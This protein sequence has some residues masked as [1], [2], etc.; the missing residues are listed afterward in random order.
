M[1]KNYSLAASM[2][3]LVACNTTPKY[4]ING[5]VSDPALNG[6]YVYLT[7]FGDKEM[8]TVDSAQIVD[9]KFR[10]NNEL[11]EQNLCFLSINTKAIAP[12][13]P[14]SAYSAVVVL[15]AAPLQA[16]LDSVF[17]TVTGSPENDAFVA[18]KTKVQELQK[19]FPE[20]L[21]V[22][23]S[24]D[25]DAAK[26]AGEKLMN[27]QESVFAEMKAYVE[28][29]KNT[30]TGGLTFVD[31]RY[32]LSEEEQN[33]IIAGADSTFLSVPG[34]DRI[35]KHLEVL[36]TV[37]VG[38]Q[39]VDFEM[40]DVDGKARKLSEFVGQGKV[41]LIDFWASWCGPCRRAMPDLIKTYNAYKGKG[42][43][44]IGISLDSKDAD[45]KKAIKDLGLKWNH[46]SDL[47]GWKSAGGALYGVNSIP[48]TVLVDKDGVIAAKNLHGD[49]L[50]SKIEELLAK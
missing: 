29:H 14:N 11:P 44:V 28:S 22:Y 39:F 37:A 16:H 49:E 1:K 46:L 36:K 13:G 47:K 43:D 30:K 3:L 24:E 21:K 50:N 48:H 38:K 8:Q 45:W 12:F 34:V 2:L 17:S 26:Q 32:S 35:V 6:Q 41:V 25:K 31:M 18:M 9:G 10:F 7:N 5:T 42:F 15:D 20:L 33:A 27:I 4:E 23:R 19:D 40:A